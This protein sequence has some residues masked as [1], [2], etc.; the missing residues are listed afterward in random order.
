[1]V[2]SKAAFFVTIRAGFLPCILLTGCTKLSK[3]PSANSES[4]STSVSPAKSDN[5][6]PPTVF[7]QNNAPVAET[8]VDE[9]QLVGDWK[10]ASIVQVRDTPAKDETVVWHITKGRE[11]GKLKIRADKIV[12]RKAIT[13]GTLD[14]RYDKS[15]KAIICEYEQGTWR[16]AVKGDTMDGTL[17]LP[18]RA[19][20]RRVKL[21]RSK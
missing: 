11:P 1:M 3:Q 13:M 16:L 17:T 8:A 4:T 12:N 2:A 6:A 10:G 14:F 21:Q 15:Q 18:D 7:D 9:S 20:L 19:V 5:A